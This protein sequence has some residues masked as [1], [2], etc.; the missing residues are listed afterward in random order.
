MSSFTVWNTVRGRLLVAAIGVELLMLSFL[1]ANSAR[2]LYGAMTQQAAW[3]AQQIAPVLNAALK[4]P[5]A[6]RD[7]ATLQAVLDESRATDGILYLAVLDREGS[8]VAS[9]G[10]RGALDPVQLGSGGIQLNRNSLLPQYDVAA[11][12]EQ[13][14]QRLG[15]LR[16][17]V[18]LARVIEAR[19]ILLQ[20]GIGIAVVELLLSTLVL[21]LIGFWLTRH[22]GVLTRTSMQVAKGNLTPPAVPEGP[23]D[24]G[25]LGA[26]FNI[27]SRVIAERIQELEDLNRTLEL[28]IQ[29]EVGKNRE[30]DS[31]MLQQDKMASIGQLAAG[32][33]HEINNPM[34]FIISNLGTLKEYSE[35]LSRYVESSAKLIPPDSVQAAQIKALQEQLDLA[36]I[37]DDMAP[38]LKESLEG[39]DRVKQIVHGLKDFARMDDT[40][41]READ[42]NQCINSTVNIVRNELKYVAD[43]DLKLGAIPPVVCNPQQ[44]NQVIANLLVNAAQAIEG[45]GVITVITYEESDWVVLEV[46][47]T[48]QGM[49]PEVIKRVFDPFYTTKPV[50][51]GTGLGLTISYDMV[52]KNGGEISVESTPGS[53][54]CFT[55]RLP[56][57]PA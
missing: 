25:Q 18:S 4:A 44:I 37:I 8:V 56:V 11:A 31:Y 36:Y 39:A 12:I 22:L 57:L 14:G 46:A 2:L 35:A 40:T 49:T 51:K 17:G 45:H 13:S 16:Y 10:V 29:D 7:F 33:A 20:Q 41:I 54:T 32:V 23:D 15:I 43:L 52:R 42:L 30:K 55:V 53:G 26:A 50:G 3:H 48:G 47:D 1:V 27:M 6:Q 19:S 24:I 38:L 5:L 34:G 21:T 28:R 9:S